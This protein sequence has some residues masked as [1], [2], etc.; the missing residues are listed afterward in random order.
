MVSR[1]PTPAPSPTLGTNRSGLTP[2]PEDET[3]GSPTD[4]LVEKGKA[5]ARDGELVGPDLRRESS[6]K[7]SGMYYIGLPMKTY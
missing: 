1:P 6:A 5:R 3:H 4:A 7:E 2:E